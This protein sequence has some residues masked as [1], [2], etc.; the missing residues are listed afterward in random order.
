[1]KLYDIDCRRMTDR[2]AAHAYLKEVLALPDYYGHNLDALYDCLTDIGEP[3]VLSLTAPESL[4]RS[5]G[6]YGPAL[7]DTIRDAVRDDPA[8]R[9]VLWE[10]DGGPGAPEEE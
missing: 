7:L 3:T 2:S 9:L 5:M 8:L 10:E 4:A 1:M 6:E